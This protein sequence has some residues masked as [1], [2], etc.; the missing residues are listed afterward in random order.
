MTSQLGS[1][2]FIDFQEKQLHL[3]MPFSLK[4][5]SASRFDT[6]VF[7]YSSNHLL[8]PRLVIRK[9]KKNFAGCS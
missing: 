4:I 1:S 8:S 6:A 3:I 9:I 2:R 5:E 7:H